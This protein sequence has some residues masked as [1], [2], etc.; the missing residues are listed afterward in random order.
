MNAIAGVSLMLIGAVLV[1]SGAF[2]ILMGWR[3]L[4]M[5]R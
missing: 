5:P 4:W 3:I 1:L 2:A